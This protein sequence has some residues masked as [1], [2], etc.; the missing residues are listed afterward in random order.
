MR[1]LKNLI[2]RGTLTARSTVLTPQDLGLG[3]EGG[4]TPLCDPAGW[5]EALPP[6]PPEGL[7]LTG[8]LERIE[9][10]FIDQALKRSNANESQAARLLKLNHHTFRYRHRKLFR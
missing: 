5:R 1:E 4:N 3:R 8:T 2:E 7:D 9:R 6:L 10:H